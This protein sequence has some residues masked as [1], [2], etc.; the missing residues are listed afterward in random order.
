M[1]PALA[2]HDAILRSAVEGWDGQVIKTTGDGLTA[3]FSSVT[4][5]VQAC[6]AAQ[7]SLSEEP[8]ADTGDL[9]VRM[10]LHSG[11]WPH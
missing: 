7:R 2:R 8:W 4:A 10:G 3:V 11:P 1:K 6:I 5:A 9:R